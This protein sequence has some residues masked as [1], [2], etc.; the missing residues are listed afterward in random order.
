MLVI[1]KLQLLCTIITV[2]KGA[3]SRVI[4]KR[5]YYGNRSAGLYILLCIVLFSLYLSCTVNAPV[6]FLS[7]A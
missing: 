5:C 3:C 7:S 1:Y 4:Y 2:W 6:L